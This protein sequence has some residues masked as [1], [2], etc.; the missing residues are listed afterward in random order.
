MT[1]TTLS[2]PK[3]SE[4]LQ[5]IAALVPTGARVADVGTDHAQ[6]P[7]YLV[8]TK[9]AA[10]VIGTDLHQGPYER[11]RQTVQEYALEEYIAIRLGDG[12]KV[13]EPGEVDTAVIAG[14][15][16]AAIRKILSE[17]PAVVEN[18]RKAV[19]QPM[20][21]AETVRLWLQEQ[22]W[23]ITQEDLI[24]EDKQ[25]YQIIAAEPA[26]LASPAARDDF[27]QRNF[28]EFPWDFSQESS[29]EYPQEA[30]VEL[31]PFYGPLLIC[32]RHPLLPDLLRRDL[33]G[34]Q[35]VL[36]QL[37]KSTQKDVQLRCKEFQKQRQRMKELREWLLAAK[38]S[39]I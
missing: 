13:V 25:Y 15:G 10:Y 28:R 2:W 24:Y 4:R 6:L 21:N 37:G 30:F 5:T 8:G 14:M 32:Q 23:V 7:C 22:G 9:K 34:L 39:S 27:A 17:S 1:R 26:S 31:E 29:Q 35:V 18:L 11:A 38:P 3:L 12:L 16:G 19:L 20:T 36:Q 33:A